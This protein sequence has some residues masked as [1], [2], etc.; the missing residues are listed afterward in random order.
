MLL[1]MLAVTRS[2]RSKKLLQFAV[3]LEGLEK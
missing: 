1:T 2:C 3:E